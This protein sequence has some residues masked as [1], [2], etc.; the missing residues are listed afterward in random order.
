M[1]P[2]PPCLNRL[3]KDTNSQKLVLSSFLKRSAS[4]FL[5][6]SAFLPFCMMNEVVNGSDMFCVPALVGKC[7]V[8]ADG[9][10]DTVRKLLLN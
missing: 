4:Y 1:Y 9:G 5:D 3:S 10:H 7:Y 8:K 2:Q 6:T